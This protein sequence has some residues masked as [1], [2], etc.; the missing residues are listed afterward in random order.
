MNCWEVGI[1][2]HSFRHAF[3]QNTSVGVDILDLIWHGHTAVPDV[4]TGK[5][6]EFLSVRAIIFCC[7]SD[8]HILGAA[9]T[10]TLTLIN[11]V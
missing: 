2:N 1:S 5:E 4:G 9:A 11:S 10:T 3:S 7:Q 8:F 6:L